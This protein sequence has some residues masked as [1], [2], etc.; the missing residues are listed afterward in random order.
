[1]I[2][3]FQFADIKPLSSALCRNRHFIFSGL[4]LSR[5][6]SPEIAQA[7]TGDQCIQLVL[8]N[9][10]SLRVDQVVCQYSNVQYHF[11]QLFC[12]FFQSGD[13]PGVG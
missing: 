1:M 2:Y 13:D 8:I 5:D 10:R 7:A 9:N 6:S 3:P 12:S 4:L 11:V